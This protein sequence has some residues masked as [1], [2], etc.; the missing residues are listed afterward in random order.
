MTLPPLSMLGSSPTNMAVRCQSS[1]IASCSVD[2]M[3]AYNHWCARL[4]QWMAHPG[5]DMAEFNRLCR[6][7]RLD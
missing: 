3:D 7:Y 1:C 5:F 4:D 2:T 6:H